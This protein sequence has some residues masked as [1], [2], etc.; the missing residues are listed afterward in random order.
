[1]TEQ[2]L[3]VLNDKIRGLYDAMEVSMDYFASMNV[4]CG[5]CELK[6]NTA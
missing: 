6:K 4:N 5:Y 3:N 2:D 1:M